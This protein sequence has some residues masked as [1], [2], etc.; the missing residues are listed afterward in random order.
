MGST[1]TLHNHT[2]L[3][4][5]NKW[6]GVRTSS[7]GYCRVKCRY[8]WQVISHIGFPWYVLNSHAK[9]LEEVKPTCLSYTKMWLFS[10]IAQGCMV[11]QNNKLMRNQKVSP[12]F[13]WLLDRQKIFFSCWIVQLWTSESLGVEFHG[14]PLLLMLLLENS[15]NTIVRCVAYDADRM[16]TIV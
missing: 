10:Q 7:R 5:S 15:T 6:Q 1:V 16:C 2:T 9:F 13:K 4:V 11:W 8:A 14:E 12:A 3:R